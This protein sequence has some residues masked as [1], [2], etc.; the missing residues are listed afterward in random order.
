MITIPLDIC[1]HRQSVGPGSYGSIFNRTCMHC[2]F[3]LA[4]TIY[5]HL[6]QSILQE[7]N[8]HLDG[9]V[10]CCKLASTQKKSLLPIYCK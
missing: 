6:L 5:L 7:V 8:T 4:M 10:A 2:D 3:S 9:N 1:L